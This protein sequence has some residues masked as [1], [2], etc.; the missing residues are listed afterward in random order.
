MRQIWI[1][2]VILNS[3]QQTAVE[4]TV[5]EAVVGS[6]EEVAVAMQTEQAAVE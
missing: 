4:Q 5:V 6:A 3:E 1:V 2:E